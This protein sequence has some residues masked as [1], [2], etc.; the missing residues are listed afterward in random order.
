MQDAVD[1]LYFF[2]IKNGQFVICKV[3]EGPNGQPFCQ[4]VATIP[5]QLNYIDY[6]PQSPQKG[7]TQ[8]VS[9]GDRISQKSCLTKMGCIWFSQAVNCDGMIQ[10]CSGT[11]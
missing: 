9:S 4:K 6:P 1:D 3:S 8:K 5:H 2:D 7:T 11:R 10:L